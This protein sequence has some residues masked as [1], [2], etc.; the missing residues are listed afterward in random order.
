VVAASRFAGYT[1]C[2]MAACRQFA[3]EPL[4][5]WDASSCN[6]RPLEWTGA[7][8]LIAYVCCRCQPADIFADVLPKLGFGA[9]DAA[10]KVSKA[11]WTVQNFCDA[12]ACICKWHSCSH[13]P[14]TPRQHVVAPVYD[15][16]WLLLCMLH[17]P[18]CP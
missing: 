16:V 10:T 9:Q 11:L 3:A 15:S 6:W 12:Y 7:P 5:N 1:D 17:P 18:F 8:V 13:A 2:P 14:P 4:T